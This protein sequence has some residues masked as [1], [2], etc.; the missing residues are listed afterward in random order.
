MPNE[1]HYAV[2]AQE[3]S[4]QITK[5]LI[6]DQKIDINDL[7]TY[8][9]TT[10]IEFNAQR[11]SLET[12]IYLWRAAAAT[13]N[14][15]KIKQIIENYPERL[16]EETIRGENILFWASLKVNPATENIL[17]YINQHP[18]F[19]ISTRQQFNNFHICQAQLFLATQEEDYY[20]QALG[21]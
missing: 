15:D 21:R 7:H 4:L 9:Q 19:K 16:L 10:A 13:G 12:F 20:L 8:Y 18:D 17:E 6:E 11:G 3:N 14:I 1:L 5:Q 2:I